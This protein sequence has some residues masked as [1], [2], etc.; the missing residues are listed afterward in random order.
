[1]TNPNRKTE[2]ASSNQ[3]T[4]EQVQG[5]FS[6][7]TDV[8]PI[9]I[10]LVDILVSDFTAEAPPNLA[11]QQETGLEPNPR[12]GG[13]AWPV[14]PDGEPLVTTD[15]AQVAISRNDHLRIR[16]SLPALLANRDVRPVSTPEDVERAF[17]KL[18]NH[19]QEQGV[20]CTL[21]NHPVGRVD[22]C[23]NVRT[24]TPISELKVLLEQRC[25]PIQSPLLSC[26]KT[27]ND[28]VKWTGMRRR[29]GGYDREITFCNRPQE[30]GADEQN[31]QRFTYRLQRRSAVSSTLGDLT[32]SDLC[33]SLAALRS[34]F[35]GAVA[36]L[37]PAP[38]AE[39]NSERLDQS[40]DAPETQAEEPADA[41]CGS[42]QTTV[43]QLRW[44]LAR[45]RSGSRTN[46]D[47]F[48]RLTW[49]LLFAVYPDPDRLEEMLVLAAA[50]KDGPIGGKY[51]AEDKI[52]AARR[53][54][55]QLGR[56]GKSPDPRVVQLG[57]KLF[58]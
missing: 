41:N 2:N 25:V 55:G 21:E 36:R 34:T 54:A 6:H 5:A 49:P 52:K 53:R 46:L 11:D 1:M 38:V 35:R 16:A 48:D 31:I 33:Q 39:E 24:E 8:S 12:F 15:L 26:R 43:V 42:P 22:I 7:Q 13:A 20:Q 18:E 40:S 47:E 29:G 44:L 14:E 32:T 57:K 17:F 19:L 9:G 45:I 28:G 23:R 50:S 27:D 3:S 37:F 10:D 30:P 51:P 58:L 4:G 56:N